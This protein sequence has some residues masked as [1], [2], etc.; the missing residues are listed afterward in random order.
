M[1][2]IFVQDA[3]AAINTTAKPVPHIAIWTVH[4]CA[5]QVRHAIGKVWN[6]DDPNAGWKVARKEGME[7]VKIQMRALR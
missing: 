5:S 4:G 6:P 2:K 3:F 7:C 1:T